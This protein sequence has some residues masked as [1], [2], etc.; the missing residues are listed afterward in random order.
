MNNTPKIHY[1]NFGT[2]T[3]SYANSLVEVMLHLGAKYGAIL[4]NRGVK[5]GVIIVN[6]ET[7]TISVDIDAMHQI[8]ENFD[9]ND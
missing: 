8:Q 2:Q 9:S 7:L 4:Y 1:I 6:Q 5:E 3:F